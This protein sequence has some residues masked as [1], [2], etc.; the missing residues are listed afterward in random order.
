MQNLN[1]VMGLKFKIYHSTNLLKKSTDFI[2]NSCYLIF[3]FT[4][5][6]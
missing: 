5:E 3:E 6:I 2:Y 1:M 4:I